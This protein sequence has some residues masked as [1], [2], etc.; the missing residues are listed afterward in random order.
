MEAPTDPREIKCYFCD[1]KLFSIRH[2]YEKFFALCEKCLIGLEKQEV[3]Q[4]ERLNREIGKMKDSKHFI[5][6][7]ER[8]NGSS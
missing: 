4:V 2:E 1:K 3:D 7:S 8:N 6:A 5:H